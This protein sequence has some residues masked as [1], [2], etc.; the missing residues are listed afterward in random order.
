MRLGNDSLVK[1]HQYLSKGTVVELFI[2]VCLLSTLLLSSLF[3]LSISKALYEPSS[4]LGQIGADYGEL[5]GHILIVLSLIFLSATKF[6]SETHLGV[7]FP[8][9]M[10]V[11]ANIYLF[12]VL[13]EQ[14]GIQPDKSTLFLVFLFSILVVTGLFVLIRSIELPLKD[15]IEQVA[16]LTISLGLMGPLIAVQ[17]LKLL[18]GR[19]RYRD[20]D[21]SHSQFSPWFE[22]QGW[23][24]N[25]S[26]PSGHTAMGWMVLPLLE[27]TKNQNKFVRL[28][29][30]FLVVIWG[31]FVAWSRVVLGAHYFS[32][33][34]ASTI[35]LY[36]F[37]VLLK[38]YL[39]RT[40]PNQD[41]S[42]VEDSV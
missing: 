12:I 31:L 27:L 24:G 20:L 5:P 23:T 37:Y 29:V 14:L 40:T 21:S 33:V 39:T 4:W 11:A 34:I 25:Y 7:F 22:P 19:S 36:T 18:W 6:S 35:L 9:L 32:D 42:I 38:N 41:R 1:F 10:L 15:K 30:C 16:L 13:A 28:L 26:F 8:A 17:S 2:F 3:D